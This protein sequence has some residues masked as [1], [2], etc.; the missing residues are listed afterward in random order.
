MGDGEGPQG[1]AGA[2]LLAWL[3]GCPWAVLTRGQLTCPFKFLLVL[4]QAKPVWAVRRYRIPV[5]G[6]NTGP[7]SESRAKPTGRSLAR[8]CVCVLLR[9]GPL[10]R[11]GPGPAEQPDSWGEVGPPSLW[12]QAGL[13]K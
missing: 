7:G 2:G 1:T 5:L 10:G 12:P 4:K 13:G 11:R 6:S 8:V 9:G 3:A